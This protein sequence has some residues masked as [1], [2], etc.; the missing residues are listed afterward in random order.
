VQEGMNIMTLGIVELA[1]IAMIGLVL[2]AALIGAV[3]AIV[4]FS[5]RS[6]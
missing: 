6:K 2:I 3:A 4:Y 5:K 1:I